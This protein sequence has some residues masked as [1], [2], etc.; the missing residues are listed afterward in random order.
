MAPHELAARAG[1]VYGLNW[2]TALAR[3]LPT[4]GSFETRLRRVQRWAAAGVPE[5]AVA[6][7]VQH[8]ETAGRRIEAR[9]DERDL[10][11]RTFMAFKSGAHLTSE[12]VAELM[13]RAGVELSNNRLRELGRDSDRG[14][15]ITADELHALVSM[16][17]NDQRAGGR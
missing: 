2:Q 7:L 15:S 10:R 8:L 6:W 11:R 4:P 9:D 17:A 12:D 13:R 16:W 5:T 3:D 1:A 14:A